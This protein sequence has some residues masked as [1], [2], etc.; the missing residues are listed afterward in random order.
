M[1]MIACV[2]RINT[3]GILVPGLVVT[4]SWWRYYDG[5]P[6]Y[7]IIAKPVG[8]DMFSLDGITYPSEQAVFDELLLMAANKYKCE[9]IRIK[10]Y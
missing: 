6:E 2:C 7:V 10:K 5:D 1:G 3:D 9:D 8:L 4:S